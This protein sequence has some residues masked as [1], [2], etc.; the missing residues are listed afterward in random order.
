M[1][2]H[3]ACPTHDRFL[4]CVHPRVQRLAECALEEVQR[5]GH[6]GLAK[7]VHMCT[8]A[9]NHTGKHTVTQASMQARMHTGKHAC[10]HAR[11]HARTHAMA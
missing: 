9:C 1:Q 4:A 11:T 5:S 3:V 2:N 8:H 10:K 7:L 6:T